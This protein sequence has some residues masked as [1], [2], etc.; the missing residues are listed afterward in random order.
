MFPIHDR[1]RQ[2]ICRSVFILGG[3]APMLAVVAWATV[4][5]SVSHLEAVRL[6][7]AE[8]LGLDVKLASVSYSQPG[9][10]LL[11]GLELADSESGESVASIRAVEIVRDAKLQTMVLSQPEI[12]ITRPQWL[13]T[14]VEDRL[15]R[16]S[17]ETP[18]RL[19]AGEL[20]LRWQS[21]LQTLDCNAQLDSTP[22]A[23][24]L[25]AAFQFA[26]APAGG[27]IRLHFERS[28]VS[29]EPISSVELDAR[30]AALPYPILAAFFDRRNYL[31]EKS[32]LRGSIRAMEMPDG[33]QGEFS[34]RL[35]NI[36]LNNLVSD[37]FPHR[38]SGMATMA[39]DH[40]VV[41]CGRLEEFHGTVS[42]GPGIVSESLLT[43]AA[44]HLKMRSERARPTTST[45][46]YEELSAA[47]DLE[48]RGLI[49]RG[50]C[51][52]N[53]SGIIMRGREGA[54]LWQAS[55]GPVPVVA[56]V[57]ALV[58]DSQTQVPATRQTDWLLN[59]LPI[60]DVLPHDPSAPPEARLRMPEGSIRR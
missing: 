14:L 47:F 31:G 6:Q 22:K 12:N 49:V 34:G 24:A 15:R 39:V 50:T 17:C 33:W 13:W 18:L 20:T 9:V 37:R 53:R 4:V 30:A 40:A 1:T 42:A 5:H 60:P 29:G 2:W 3:V 11:E 23:N 52:D 32:T 45:I 8:V 35:E 19:V 44:D 10:T 25:T 46:G 57:K 48:T 59:L 28:I 51:K 38:L 27:P 21:G 43:S 26:D 56:L 41:H 54:V 36:D 16:H 7:V 55:G 58:P